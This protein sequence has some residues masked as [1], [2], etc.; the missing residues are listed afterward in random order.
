[1]KNR[2]M[3]GALLFVI[4]GWLGFGLLMPF[5]F[6]NLEYSGLFGDSFGGI[7]SLFTG[8]G[9]VGLVYTLILQIESQN[10]TKETTEFDRVIKLYEHVKTDIDYFT[11]KDLSGRNAIKSFATHFLGTMKSN[12]ESF[13]D[14]C[15]K[16]NREAQA[17]AMIVGSFGHLTQIIATNQK[18]KEHKSFLNN[19]M[20]TLYY[21]NFY[22][23]KTYI[24]EPECKVLYG[25]WEDL[26]VAL[27]YAQR[28]VDSQFVK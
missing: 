15:L 17:L 20:G 5:L 21:S 11:F 13:G 4:V 12:S 19:M 28:Q 10:L 1:M 18:I 24:E 6:G 23:Y 14:F 9:F 26:S 27:S 22:Y 25:S 8:L 7:T 2:A 3:I 16:H